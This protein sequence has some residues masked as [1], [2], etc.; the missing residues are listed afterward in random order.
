M[1]T[2][3][4][5]WS[6]L[7]TGIIFFIFLGFFA[8]YTQKITRENNLSPSASSNKPPDQANLSDRLAKTAETVVTVN[9]PAETNKP[10]ILP[11]NFSIRVP[12]TSQAPFALWDALHE[13]ACEEASLLMVKHFKEG[14]LIDNKQT[15][16]DEITS[17]ISWEEQHGY[18][19]SI[20]LEQ[21]AEIA[22][23]KFNLTGT[24]ETATVETIMIEIAGGHPV[25]VG[26]AGKVLPN[27]NFR[28]GGPNYH[29]L[30]IKG[31]TS[32]SFI[33]NDPGTRLGENF[34]Y[35]YNDLLYAIHDWN[36][37]NIL[38]GA[39]KYLVFR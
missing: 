16:E 4:Q 15:A 7:I 1:K 30:V 18:G 5:K 24:I 37:D 29:M 34:V 3:H 13:D 22:R 14:S 12:F 17:L 11:E 35:S 6:R 20:T 38:N 28:N 23:I 32:A 8:F 21:L 27:P 25:I 2:N 36:S 10:V 33:T 31:Y 9:K 19:T 26:A 39:K